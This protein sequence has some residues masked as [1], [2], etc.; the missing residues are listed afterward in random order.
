[1][2]IE[3]SFRDLKSGALGAG[4]E[5]SLTHKG[6]RL[7]NLLVLFALMQLAAWLIGQCEE[8]RGEGGRLEAR[9]TMRRRHH[10]TVRLG[11]EVLKRRAWWP[12]ATALRRFLRNFASGC[13]AP[14]CTAV[15]C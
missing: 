5:H 2:T 1:M 11:M 3:Q 10:S 13:P 15:L 6:E 7:A 4:L 9:P 14:L 12:P 8:Q